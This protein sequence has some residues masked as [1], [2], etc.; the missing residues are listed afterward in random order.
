MKLTHPLKIFCKK[1]V[2]SL[3][4][5]QLKQVTDLVYH[6]EEI[7][8][9][10]KVNCICCSDYMIRRLN[11][12]YRKKDMVTDVLSFPF[13]EPDFLG[14][15]YIS[16]ERTVIQAHRFGL[17]ERDEFRRI[18]IHGLLHL[19]GYEHSEK[20]ERSVMETEESRLFNL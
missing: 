6:R 7:S 3:P 14:E 15:I 5:T 11:R 20:V 19:T 2:F 10:R 12:D 18:Y 16:L 1:R 9:A 17:S 4:V 8:R 13:D